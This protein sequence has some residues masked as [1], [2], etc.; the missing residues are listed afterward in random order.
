MS[1]TIA[2]GKTK[3]G[4]RIIKFER[5]SFDKKDHDGTL[6]NLNESTLKKTK[7]SNILFN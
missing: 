1:K 5:K 2:E 4:V 7:L 3:K 6:Y